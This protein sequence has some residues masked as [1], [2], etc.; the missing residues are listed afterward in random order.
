V[1]PNL[2]IVVRDPASGTFIVPVRAVTIADGRPTER[3]PLRVY[4]YADYVD[5]ATVKVFEKSKGVLSRSADGVAQPRYADAVG[6][7]GLTDLGIFAQWF[8]DSGFVRVQQ[9]TDGTVV[10][11]ASV[12]IYPSLTDSAT[13]D[14]KLSAACARGTTDAE[15]LATFDRRAFAACAATDDGKG[16]APRGAL[17]GA[18]EAGYGDYDRWKR[19]F[20]A[21]GGMRGVGWAIAYQDPTTGRLSNHWIGLHEEGTL[22]GFVPILV[23]DVWEHA[24]MLDY[25]PAERSK[26]IEAFFENV[27]WEMCA[28]RLVTIEL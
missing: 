13:P 6:L 19:D 22:A 5:P 20:A 23:M 24:Y 10:R 2:V 17:R 18:I 16:D 21:I 25:K 11:G 12:E 4:N 8:P 15:G 26:Y 28:A 27:N 9:L 1:S 3:G 14:R 7:V